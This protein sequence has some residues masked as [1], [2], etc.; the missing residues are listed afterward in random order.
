MCNSH[1]CYTFCTSVTLLALVLHLNCTALS[2]SE[3]SNFYMYIIS[4]ENGLNVL[5]LRIVL[6]LPLIAGLR[7][8]NIKHN[9]IS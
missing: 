8:T 1:W 4:V 7:L 9:N 5:Y 3:S 6:S 2:Q